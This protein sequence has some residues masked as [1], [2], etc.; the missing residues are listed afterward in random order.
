M[1][2]IA[3]RHDPYAALRLPNFNLFSAARNLSALGDNM[4][5]VVVGWELYGRTHRPMTLGYVGLVQALPILLFAL[6]AGHVA[7]NYPRRRIAIIAQLVFC[8][9]SLGLCAL[10]ARSAPIWLFYICLFCSASAR[11]FGNPA[12]GAL[13]PQIVPLGMLGSAI[14]WDT[15]L[16]RIAVI[17]GAALGGWAL[18]VTKAPWAV[19]VINSV[20]G[21]MSAMLLMPIVV[22][23]APTAVREK[24]TWATLAAGI[25]YIIRADLILATVSLDLF[26]V[27]LGGAVNLLPVYATDILH[28]GPDKLGWLRA[29]PSAGALLTA[30]SL[31]H[32][33]AFRRPGRVMLW[34]VA[35]FGVATVVF[36][37]STSLWLS[38]AALF[39]TGAFDM[40]SVVIR[41]TLIQTQTPDEMRGRVN[42]VNSVF[43]SSSNELGG[44]ES[45]LI[46]Q[47]F[48]P[49]VSVVSGG[50]GAVL[51]VIG[52]AAAWPSLRNYDGGPGPII[53][54]KST[55]DQ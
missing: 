44:Y 8:S 48:S 15:S 20:L 27:L 49:V 30:L 54:Q 22:R 2:S 19:Y 52:A 16:R 55:E 45:G 51:V 37:L 25:H 5:S 53:D 14:S 50:I 43:I 12:R 24:A 32:M 13:L 31:A 6:M 23:S 29:A 33:P 3:P 28:V 26:A 18:A 9:C 34:N 17:S 4:Q 40:V 39:L 1:E 46:A 7:D 36:G 47:L 10:S 41:Q 42:A 21:A 11:A 38:L 35:G